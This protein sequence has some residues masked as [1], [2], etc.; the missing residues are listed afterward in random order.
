MVLDRGEGA[1]GISDFIFKS[2]EIC[3]QKSVGNCTH[4]VRIPGRRLGNAET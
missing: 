3:W 4:C 1:F 2:E